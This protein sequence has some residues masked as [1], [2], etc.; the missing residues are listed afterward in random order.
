M[1]KSYCLYLQIQENHLDWILSTHL[2]T[3]EVQ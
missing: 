1:G 2:D 3:Q